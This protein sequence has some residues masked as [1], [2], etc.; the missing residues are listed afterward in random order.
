MP[1]GATKEQVPEM[2]QALLAERFKL[3]AV[4]DHIE[5]TPTKN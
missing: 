3:V 4:I 1:D 5:R 2:F